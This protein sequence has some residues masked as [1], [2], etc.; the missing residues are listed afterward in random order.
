V[1]E[2]ERGGQPLVGIAI[3]AFSRQREDRVEIA[4]TREIRRAPRHAQVCTTV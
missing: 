4:V 1:A 3:A 2:I